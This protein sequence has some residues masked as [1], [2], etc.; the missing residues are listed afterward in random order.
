MFFFFLAMIHTGLGPEQVGY[1]FTTMNIP[2]ITAKAL[3]KREREIGTSIE[4][5]AEETC[6]QA[7]QE[8]IRITYD[9]HLE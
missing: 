4:K 8:E 5:K 3:K 1:F 6:K 9:G 2:P 7:V